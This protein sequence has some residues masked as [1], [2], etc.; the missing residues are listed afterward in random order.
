MLFKEVMAIY[1]ENHMI[2]AN[3][4]CGYS[5]ELYV[6]KVSYTLGFSY[7]WTLKV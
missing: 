1:T 5:A 7:S 2:P 6:V 3:T 4:L